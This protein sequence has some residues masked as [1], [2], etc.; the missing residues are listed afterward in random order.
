MRVG[1]IGGGAAGLATAWLLDQTHDVV[2]LERENRLGGHANTLEI[3]R[4][5]GPVAIEAGFEFYSEAMFPIFH[6]LLQILRVEHDPFPMTITLYRPDGADT[7]GLP[8]VRGG[9]VHWP[10]FRPRQLADLVRFR[11]VLEGA[12]AIMRAEDRATTLQHYLDDIGAPEAFRER[13]L[14]PFLQ[15]SWCVERADLEQFVAYNALRYAWLHRRTG[16]TSAPWL[17]VRGGARSYVQ[18]LARQLTRTTVRTGAAIAR[19]TRAGGAYRVEEPGGRA[20]DVDHLVLATNA[21]QASE[22]LAG[23][24][25]ATALR[26]L[27]SQVEYFPTTISIHGDRRL[28]PPRRSDWATINMRHDG[29]HSQATVWKGWKSEAPIFRSWTTFDRVAPDPLY[30]AARYRHGKVNRAYFR[31]QRELPRFQ[32]VDNL[33]VAGLYTHDVDC[34]ESAVM[35]GIKIAERLAPGSPRLRRLLGDQAEVTVDSLPSAG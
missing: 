11:Q 10:S 32:G 16:L 20:H 12:G 26:G 31:V 29:T 6:R 4:G 21:E 25:A 14:Y 9:R 24:P 13:F 27:L 15:A 1:I 30:A 5:D 18:A 7:I 22:L 3:D 2:L 35:S 34:H 33:W 28:M 23:L 17:E 8:P 19:L